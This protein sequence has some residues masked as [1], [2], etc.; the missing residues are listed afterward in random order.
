ML[1]GG[2]GGRR[3]EGREPMRDNEAA[4]NAGKVAGRYRADEGLQPGEA[5]A[6]ALVGDRIRDRPILD[7]G[8][9]GGRT[10]A[11]LR[12]MTRDYVG[13]DFSADMVALCRSRFPELDI[14]RA[15]AR[16]LSV[17]ADRRFALA[18]FSYNGIDYVGHADRLRILAELRRVLADDGWLLF[19]SHNRACP[20]RRPWNPGLLG[21]SDAPLPRRLAGW[22]MGIA[23]H[24]A[25]RRL[26]QADATHAIVNDEG[27]NF[28]L[29]TYYIGIE[30]QRAQ[31]ADA[32]FALQAAFRADGS[33]VAA[34]D[35]AAG[36]PWIN[37]LARKAAG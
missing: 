26:E 14:R 3:R 7:L 22:L 30:A 29:L 27:E 35:P 31:L 1:V 21:A 15:D 16:D 20:V 6:L 28:R 24:L 32:G 5:A 8:V 9:G 19:S 34:G 23:R 17:F 37:Y 4:W 10:A 33:P 25:R 2:E 36:S 11:V 12:G 18:M 13:I